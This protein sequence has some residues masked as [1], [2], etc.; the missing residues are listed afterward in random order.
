MNL[1]ERL[2]GVAGLIT[3]GYSIADIGT[4]HGYIPIYMALNGLTSKAFAMDVNKGPLERAAENIIRYD[5]SQIVTARLSNGLQRLEPFEAETIVIAGM[6]GIL[7]NSILQDGIKVAKT[8]KELILSPHSDV[9]LVRDFLC[10][11]G[12]TI[13]KENMVFEEGKYY[14]ILKAVKGE[15]SISNEVDRQFGC[16]KT[17][18]NSEV[19]H[20]FLKHELSKRETIKEKMQHNK[21]NNFSRLNELE[22]EM[23]IIRKALEDYES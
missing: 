7:I 2:K 1:S 11:N 13:E 5:V 16:D 15:M 21:S 3:P 18:R 6:G 10:D 14:F 19:M 22:E 20:A 4:D 17:L 9:A 12:F 23:N 8:A